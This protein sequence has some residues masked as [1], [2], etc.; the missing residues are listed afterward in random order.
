M[1]LREL[2]RR[3]VEAWQAK[4]ESVPDSAWTARTPCK[5]WDVRSLVNHVVGE[6]L[7]TPPI[8]EGRTVDEVGDRFDG[9]VLGENPAA[10][11]RAAATAAVTAADAKLSE[12][13]IVHLSFGDF[14]VEEYVWQLSADHLVH[15]WDLAAGAGLDRTLDP[16]LVAAVADW[17]TE[18]EELYRSAGAIGPRIDPSADPDPQSRLLAAFG[19]DPAW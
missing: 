16:E 4:V 7:W 14:P 15:C 18:R 17:F 1:E 2:H 10:T 5:D 19:R 9:D 6:E 8:T 12:G 11:G 3:A 13:G